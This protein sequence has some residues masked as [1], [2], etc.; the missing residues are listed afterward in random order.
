MFGV[1]IPDED[2]DENFMRA[3]APPTGLPNPLS[4]PSLSSFKNAPKQV[5][6]TSSKAIK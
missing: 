6:P 4:M 3:A 5:D 1:S 2:D